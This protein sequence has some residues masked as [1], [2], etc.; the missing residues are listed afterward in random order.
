MQSFILRTFAV[1]H[2]KLVLTQP[3]TVNFFQLCCHNTTKLRQLAPPL[4]LY[5]ASLVMTVQATFNLF[6]QLLDFLM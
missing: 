5:A 6:A 2:L 1:F 3:T 4:I